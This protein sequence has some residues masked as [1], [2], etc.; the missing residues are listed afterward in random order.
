MKRRQ[1]LAAGAAGTASALFGCG[2]G[3]GGGGSGTMT[4][5]PPPPTT[6][7][8]EGQLLPTLPSLPNTSADPL[9]FTASLSAAPSQLELQS[10]PPAGLWLYNGAFPGPLI[11]LREGQRV[12]VR[13]DNRLPI[14]T[15]VHWHGLPVPPDQDGSPMDPIA[16]GGARVYAYDVPA[17]SAGTYWYHPHAHQTTALQVARGLAAPLIVRSSDDPLS[18]LPDVTLFVS[19]VRLDAAGQVSP[20]SPVDA[21]VGR[22]GEVLLVNGKRLPVHN[23]RPGTTQRWRILNATSAHYLRLSLEGHSLILVGTDG[24]L[25]AAP[26][27]GLSEILVAPAQRVEVVVRVSGTPNARFRL[28]ALRHAADSMGFGAYADDDLMTV[29]TSA[30]SPV[31][32]V[33][34]PAT[35]RALVDPGPATT[36]QRLRLDQA[37][38]GMG[39]GAGMGMLNFTINGRTF[40]PARVDL[41]TQA[42]RIEEWDIV[43]GTMMDHPIHIHGT[44][45]QLLRR[46]SGATIT[47]A[48]FAAWIDTVD[49]P[50][51]ESATIKVRQTMPGKRMFHCHILEHEDAGMMGILDV[52]P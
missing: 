47:P 34:L 15:T 20:M 12:S 19:G 16:S 29:Q 9:Q 33:A 4:G 30:E 21:M 13:V 1:F 40:D 14:D 49:V 41:T 48:P 43:N 3:D 36:R 39:M 24:G 52:A 32:P 6:A 22:Q 35:L 18:P 50:A 37:G 31:P 23:L 17:G 2:G 5:G 28:R 51:G 11:E 8:V 45:F 46:Q 42:G 10:G 44:Q 26:Q 25:L 7:L 38:M 27:P